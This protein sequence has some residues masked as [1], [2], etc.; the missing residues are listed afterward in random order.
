M[1]RRWES[2]KSVERRGADDAGYT[3][4]KKFQKE[5]NI[6]GRHIKY[7]IVCSFRAARQTAH[8][9][10]K[11]VRDHWAIDR[12]MKLGGDRE[13]EIPVLYTRHLCGA[14]QTREKI[15]ILYTQSRK[16]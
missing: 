7:N 15:N 10:S 1:P 4:V 8:P 14:G 6:G 13:R 3:G 2:R 5:H 9:N 16:C 11:L 12:M